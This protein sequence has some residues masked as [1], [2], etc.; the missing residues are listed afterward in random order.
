[1]SADRLFVAN[2]PE[3]TVF[4]REE[5]CIIHSEVTH[6]FYHECWARGHK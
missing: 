3:K 4:S 5:L 6:A 2:A 1:M